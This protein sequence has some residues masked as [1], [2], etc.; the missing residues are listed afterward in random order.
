MQGRCR[1]GGVLG[2]FCEIGYWLPSP[3][4]PFSTSRLSASDRDG[5][6]SGWR[7]IQA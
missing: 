5:F 4:S 7:A 3:S 6:G 2:L 1:C